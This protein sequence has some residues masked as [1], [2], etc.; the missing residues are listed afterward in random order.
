MDRKLEKVDSNL[1]VDFMKVTLLMDN[2][3][4]KVNIILDNLEKF[5]EV[6]LLI[7]TWKAKV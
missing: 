6:I 1:K 2:F 4:D 7:I 3:M 5:M